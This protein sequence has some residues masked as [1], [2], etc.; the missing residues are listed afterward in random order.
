VI[1]K[2]WREKIDPSKGLTDEILS[3]MRAAGYDVRETDPFG[4][5]V[6]LPADTHGL[7]PYVQRIWLM[8]QEMRASII[9][10]FPAAPRLPADTRDYLKLLDDV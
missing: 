5:R 6:H 9:D 7:S 10:R 1:V 2:L 8:W 3:T 4:K